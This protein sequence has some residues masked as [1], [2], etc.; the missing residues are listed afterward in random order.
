MRPSQ[1]TG[2]ISL[3]GLAMQF[4]GRR[5]GGLGTGLPSLQQ[6][7]KHFVTLPLFGM[8]FPFDDVTHS[9]PA[10]GIK[11]SAVNLHRVLY[12]A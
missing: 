9:F 8:Y 7:A 11:A 2:R 10:M 5:S 4:V 1:F 3:L 6:R 12:P